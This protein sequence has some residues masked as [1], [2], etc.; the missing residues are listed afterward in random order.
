MGRWITFDA[1]TTTALSQSAGAEHPV[2]ERHADLLAELL[3]VAP[4][5]ALLRADGG[6][7]AVL[8]VRKNDVARSQALPT[9]RSEATGFLGLGDEVVYEDEP[10]TPR[11]SWWKRALD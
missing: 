9:L 3:A 10:E 11:K 2:E 8:R 7:L 1:D 6:Q 5:T 4:A